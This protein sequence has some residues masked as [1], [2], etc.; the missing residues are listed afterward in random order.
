MMAAPETRQQNGEQRKGAER[1][2]AL[3]QPEAPAQGLE[4]RQQPAGPEQGSQPGT[5]T[6][7]AQ[8]PEESNRDRVRRLLLVP[9][10]FRFRRGTDAGEARRSLDALADELGYMSDASLSALRGMLASKGEGAARCFW[11]D[12]ATFR[13]FAEIVQPRPLEEVPALVRWFRSVEGPR[14]VEAGTLVET[15]LW[16]EKKKAPPLTP[17][18]RAMVAQRAQQNHRRLEVIS[19]RRAREVR[20]D[21]QD[22]EWERWYRSTLARVEALVARVQR[23]KQAQDRTAGSAA[24]A[25][26]TGAAPQARPAQDTTRPTRTAEEMTR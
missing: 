22:L 4:G 9:L 20:N 13:G 25:Q 11:P 18:A 10:G 17:Q 26:G 1:R 7:G 14:A 8:Q 19:D 2:E 23:E 6:E 21:A 5:A 24:T 12:L 15:F 3:Q 16:F